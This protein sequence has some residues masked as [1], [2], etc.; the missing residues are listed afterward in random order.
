MTSPC[1]RPG[2]PT[3]ALRQRTDAGVAVDDPLPPNRSRIFSPVRGA[4]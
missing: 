1:R 4:L 2:C 3:V